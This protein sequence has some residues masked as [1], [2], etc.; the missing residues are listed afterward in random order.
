MEILDEVLMASVNTLFGEGPI[1]LVQDNS[2]VHKSRVVRDWLEHH[3]AVHVLFWPSRSPDVNPI[4]HVW[5]YIA[6][7]W[8]HRNERT[9]KAIEQHALEVWERL[10]RSPSLIQNLC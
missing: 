4:K 7:E 5:G 6:K 2:S 9:P 10:R 1:F 8:D 3:A